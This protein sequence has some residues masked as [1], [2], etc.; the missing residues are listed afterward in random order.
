MITLNYTALPNQQNCK[1]RHIMRNI[2][3]FSHN[4]QK[5]RVQTFNAYTT[6]YTCAS[7]A[8]S[9]VVFRFVK[10]LSECVFLNTCS[11]NLQRLKLSIFLPKLFTGEIFCIENKVISIQ[12]IYIENVCK[13]QVKTDSGCRG[14]QTKAKTD[15]GLPTTVCFSRNP[16]FRYAVV[17]LRLISETSQSFRGL[18][19]FRIFEN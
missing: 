19:K 9:S 3:P 1:L 14:W 4:K 17:N 18:F 5:T 2:A 12:N 10:H 6:N 13:P 11:V 16:I 8:F 15:S 7:L